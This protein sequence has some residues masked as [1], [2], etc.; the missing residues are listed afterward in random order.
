MEGVKKILDEI[1]KAVKGKRDVIELL[2]TAVL[3]QGH[4]LLEDVPGVGKT[5]LARAVAASLGGRFSRVQFTSDLLPSDILGVSVYSKKSEDFVF[6]EGPVFSHFLLADEIN[7]SSPRT[8]SALLEAMSERN[9]SIDGE[10]RKLPTPFIVIATQNPVEQFGTYP[11]PESQLDRFSMRLSVG[12]PSR[13]NEI[14][15]MEHGV[16]DVL[17]KVSAVSSLPQLSS[18]QE[19]VVDVNVEKSLADYA[20]SIVEKTRELPSVRVGVSTRGMLSWRRMSQA[21]AF[22][23]G[24][25][26]C[27][28]DDFFELATHCLAHRLT[29]TDTEVSLIQSHEIIRSCLHAVDVPK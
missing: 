20:L 21:R 15:L 28:P 5:T 3:G 1:E 18:W 11:L 22:L 23:A 12:Y 19:K 16:D 13:D 10:T 14:A 7:R 25:D 2:F 9:V 29:F 8:Q 27:T 26:F 17:N 6:H 4:I 24:R